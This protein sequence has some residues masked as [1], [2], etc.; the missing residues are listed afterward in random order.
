MG[1]DGVYMLREIS[2]SLQYL[3]SPSTCLSVLCRFCLRPVYILVIS[4]NSDRLRLSSS[5]DIV[6]ELWRIYF[7]FY[8][9][10]TEL[11]GRPR[12]L[13]ESVVTPRKNNVHILQNNV[14][15][16]RTVYTFPNKYLH[17]HFSK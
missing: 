14:S 15:F 6:L 9:P 4:R 5:F 11:V 12:W 7:M 16:I 8:P 13:P 2:C 3:N 10:Q 17:V 1:M